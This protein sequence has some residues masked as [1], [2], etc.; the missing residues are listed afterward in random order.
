MSAQNT[1]KQLRVFLPHWLAHNNNYIA[2]FRKWVNEVRAEA[3]NE[4]SLLLEKAIC[5]LEEAGTSL[6]EALATV[7]GP[8]R[9][10]NFRIDV[11]IKGERPQS[12]EPKRLHFENHY[13][14]SWI[15]RDYLA[16]CDPVL[17]GS[18]GSHYP[19]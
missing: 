4:V 17:N 14:P 11:R 7:A 15:D 18:Q 1:I 2:E 19:Y 9:E 3:G 6:S 13:G 5:D 16:C 12:H 8:P 10:S